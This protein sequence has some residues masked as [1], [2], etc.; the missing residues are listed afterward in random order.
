[1][2]KLLTFLALVLVCRLPVAAQIAPTPGPTPDPHIYDDRAIHLVVP[3]DYTLL[4]RRTVKVSQLGGKLEPIAAWAKRT[5]RGDQ[6]TISL[7]TEGDNERLGAWLVTFKN[8]AREQIQNV[9]FKGTVRG[10]LK[11]GMPAYW[12]DLSYGTGF[13]SH[14]RYGWVWSD[15]QRGVFLSIDFPLGMMTPE[16]AQA[17]LANVRATLYP[18]PSEP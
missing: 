13:D 10:K 7:A 4:G 15:G 6:I 16:Q 12:V 18:N 8:E 3:T 1:M 17:T 2:K 5:K 11:N 9:F 14:K